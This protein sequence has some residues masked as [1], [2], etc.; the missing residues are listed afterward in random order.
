MAEPAIRSGVTY[1]EYVAFDE[2][3][4]RK[5]E[6]VRGA[7]FAM[8]G[9]TPEH[10]RLPA[11]LGE[12]LGAALRA[13]GCVVY[14]S[15]LRVR[16]EAADRA[17]YPDLTV[18][19]GPLETSPIDGHAAINPTVIVEVLSE[20]TELY[21]RSDKWSDYQRLAS[22]RHY[23]LVSQDRHRVEVYSRTDLGWHYAD[24]QE[25]GTVALTALDVSFEI[26]ALYAR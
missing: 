10:A 4:E 6:Y 19:C 21:D 13:R 3:A 2:A 18:I 14:S 15:D 20:S 24:V 26:E 5:N 1:A 16:I 23:V 12:L 7:I 17:A 9:G 8:T 11:R 25:R 22:L